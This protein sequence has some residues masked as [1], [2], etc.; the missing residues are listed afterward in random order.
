MKQRRKETSQWKYRNE[1]KSE[2]DRKEKLKLSTMIKKR[3]EKQ[4]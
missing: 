1:K 2:K 4:E 3:E